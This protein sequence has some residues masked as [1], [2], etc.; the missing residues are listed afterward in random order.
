MSLISRL[1]VGLGALFGRRKADE[2]LDSEL[3]DYLDAAV[4]EKVRRGMTRDEAVRSAHLE[5][6]SLESVKEEVRDVGWEVMIETFG[7]DVRFA[8][9]VMAK[10]PGFTLIAVLT[11]ALGIGATT[12]IFSAV[13]TVLLEPLPYRQAER[14][15]TI[16]GVN[17]GQRYDLVSDLDYLDWKSQN[18]VFESMGASTDEMF[19][20]TGAGEPESIIGYE[21]SPDFFGVLGVPPLIGRT[22]A[23]DEDEP[24]KDRV[25]VLSYHLWGGQFGGDRSVIGRSI[26]LDGQPYT[27]IGVMPPSFQYPQGTDLW[28]PL[29]VDANDTRDRGSRFLRVMARMKPGVTL[30]E[31][32]MEMGTIAARLRSAYPKTNEGYDVNLVT[33][34]QLISGDVRPALLVLLC[35][36]GLVLL[37]ACANVANLLV[38]RAVARQR[39][40]AI[41]AALGASRARMI[42]Q[43]LTESVLLGLVGGAL[44]W[45]IAY[46]GASALVAMFPKTIQNLSIPRIDSIPMDRWVLGFALLASLTTGI[47]FGLAPA[48]GAGRSSPGDSLR[49]SGRTGSGGAQGRRLRNVL[50]VSEVAFSLMLLASAALMIKSFFHLVGANLGFRPNHVLSLRVLLPEYKYKTDTQRAAFSRET[51]SR[52]QSVPGVGAAASVTFIPLSMWWGTRQVSAL[53]HPPDPAQKVP[54]P[55]W[56]A[57]TPDYFRVMR[58]PLLK[59]RF[60]S[61]TDDASTPAVAILSSS[62][63]RQLWP[64]EDPIG[65]QVSVDGLKNPCKV[66]GI[67]GDVYHLGVGIQPNGG[68][69]ELTSEVYFPYEQSPTP[70]LGYVIRTAGDPLSVAKAVQS[71]IWAV[72]KEQAISFV[73]TMDQLASE[74]IVIERS[75]MILLGAFA[76]LAVLLASI[77]IYGVI[78]YTVARRTYELGIRIALGAG[79][80]QVLRLVIGEGFVLALLGAAIGTAGALSLTRFLSSLL[81]GV[82]SADPF[83]FLAAPVV[84]LGVAV[85][86]CL[87]PARRALRVDPVVALRNE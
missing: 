10:N 5:T 64:N 82:R 68:S 79:R 77:G 46:G 4:A 48:L 33:L 78:S 41:R 70:L 56:S 81:Y 47:L 72:D 50:V 55:V 11:L 67:V 36:A 63:A 12:A 86:A 6:G 37:I 83:T 65:K 15:V 13:N 53:G 75:S 39:E 58:I 85:A 74:T 35:S 73:E 19:T 51:L 42:R 62:L 69:P 80:S 60:F 34:R 76:A 66:V 22:F 28:T 38:S 25:V 23:A 14:L 49:E 43:F 27:V 40:I 71:A 17:K 21:F 59:G 2:D 20:L 61:R 3:R 26:T 31:A 84:L 45:L 1:A 52:V 54:Q 8:L 18:R 24:G 16:W 32:R 30:P 9:R 57:I 7:R 87:V 44:G 29:T